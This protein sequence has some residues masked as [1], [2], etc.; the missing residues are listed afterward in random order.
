MFHM[1]HTVHFENR[2]EHNDTRCGRLATS[3]QSQANSN[4][5]SS[6]RKARPHLWL[7][8][9]Y[10]RDRDPNPSKCRCPVDICSSPDRRGRHLL[11]WFSFSFK[12]TL[13]PII[14]IKEGKEKQKNLKKLFTNDQTCAIMHLVLSHGPV[15]QSVSTP[16]CH[17]GGRRFESVRGR[18]KAL[19]F[20]IV[21]F[22]LLF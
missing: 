6:A 2:S 14:Q 17:A 8:F 18:Q 22:S 12:L 9:L 21:L 13:N 1:V 4:P 3:G 5:S 19:S 7:G 15:V 11:V 20:W 10:C 16:A